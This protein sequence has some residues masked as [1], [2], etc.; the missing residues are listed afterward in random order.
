MLLVWGRRWYSRKLGFVGDFCEMCRQARPFRM[1]RLTLK[2]HFW[3]LPLGETHAVAHKA[4][5][6]ACS[7]TV[8]P[9]MGRYA[10]FARK[11]AD[12]TS[13]LAQTFPAFEQA[14]AARLAIERTVRDA[15]G[16]LSATDRRQLIQTPFVLMSRAT[17]E[18]FSA[19]HV[20]AGLGLALIGL[21]VLPILAIS[22][23]DKVSPDNG[24]L[25]LLGAVGVAAGLLVW[26]A[27][28]SRA[29]WV[30]RA[31]VPRLARCLAPLTPSVAELEE[32]IGLLRQHK[33][34]LGKHLRA[35]ELLPT[36]TRRD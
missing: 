27:V 16:T 17:E 13:L 8:A 32:M 1:E 33:H 36:A 24:G 23:S 12:A 21:F 34:K 7:T 6:T 31:V 3:Y 26:Q 9:E 5:C 20:D 11:Q 28:Q 10:G 18:R 30:R 2:G 19:I 35:A 4:T 14:T 15:P 22:I 25:V 29:R